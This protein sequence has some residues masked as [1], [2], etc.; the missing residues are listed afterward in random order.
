MS[1]SPSKGGVQGARLEAITRKAFA[2]AWALGGTKMEANRMA[3]Q[4]IHEKFPE[5]SKSEI[6]ALIQS[7]GRRSG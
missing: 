5:M 6:S 1:Q 7:I 3:V 4:M 2:D